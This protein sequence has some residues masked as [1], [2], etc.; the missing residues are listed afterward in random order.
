LH[1]SYSLK[2]VANPEI[3]YIEGIPVEGLKSAIQDARASGA[4]DLDRLEELE[5]MI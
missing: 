5:K 3:E 2:Q 1:T 4:V